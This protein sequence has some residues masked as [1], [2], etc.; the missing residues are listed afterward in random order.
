MITQEQINRI[1]ELARKAKDCG[2]SE[3]EKEEQAKLRALYI[4]SIKQSL[5][6][7]LDNTYIVDK[8]GNKKKV[9]RK[10]KCKN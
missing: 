3:S 4:E 10:D 5:T 8:N 6:S 2:L 9:Q 7:Q 1:N